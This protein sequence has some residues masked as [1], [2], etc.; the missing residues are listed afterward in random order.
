MRARKRT[1][2]FAKTLRRRLSLPEA[3]L[4]N[5]LKG[6]HLEGL[7]IRKQHPIG[8]YIL[9]F[10]CDSALLCIEVDSYV[11]STEDRP[12]RDARRDAWLASHGVHTLRISA[13]LVLGDLEVAL[14]MIETTALNLIL[15][16]PPEDTPAATPSVSPLRGD[17]P[18]PDALTRWGRSDD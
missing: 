11:H 8:P 10:Y 5:R 18:P 9:D 7:H 12:E 17:P 16:R 4:W 13:A 3:V 14:R 15:K 2:A 1:R 6:R